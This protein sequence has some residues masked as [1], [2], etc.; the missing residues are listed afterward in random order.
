[1]AS[2][3]FKTLP[4]GQVAIWGDLWDD[5]NI[6]RTGF[7]NSNAANL[8]PGTPWEHSKQTRVCRT[9]R[10]MTKTKDPV[11]LEGLDREIETL[12]ALIRKASSRQSET[13]TL[14]ELT[15][16][17]DSVG[18]NSLNLS[19]MLKDRNKLA[20]QQFDPAALL[21]QALLELQEEWPELKAFSQ[22]FNPQKEE[23][24]P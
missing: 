3:W 4:N 2:F 18:R 1:L 8:D 9:R 16:L 20:N 14:E 17:L 19:R 6:N 11:T 13:L 23:P 24:T 21:H 7:L 12:R 10:E 5:R 15:G 22:Q